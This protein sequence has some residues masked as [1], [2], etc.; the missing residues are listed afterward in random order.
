MFRNV[1]LLSV[2][3]EFI[4]DDS[5]FELAHISIY[6]YRFQIEQNMEG[7]FGWLCFFGSNCD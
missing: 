6:L 4:I 5:N 2:D 7:N 3:S 1:P